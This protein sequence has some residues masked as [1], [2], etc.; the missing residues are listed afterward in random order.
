ME[1]LV[2]RLVRDEL[3]FRKKLAVLE[4]AR[5][6]GNNAEAWREFDVPKSTF[7]LRK[8]AYDRE[9]KARLKRGKPVAYTHPKRVPPKVIE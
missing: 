5:A 8:R 6:C 9:G 7:Y 3:R 1:K 4:Y 2:Q